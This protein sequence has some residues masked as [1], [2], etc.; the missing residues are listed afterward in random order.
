METKQGYINRL[1]H[2]LRDLKICHQFLYT[3]L[4][5]EGDILHYYKQEIR[6]AE[7]E[8]QLA[9]SSEAQ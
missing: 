4:Q 2:K 6:D 5:G 7:K 9:L 3:Q 8:I 1:K